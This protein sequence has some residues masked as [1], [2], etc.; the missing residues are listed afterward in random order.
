MLLLTVMISWGV[1]L[2]FAYLFVC[3]THFDYA[4][5]SVVD[6]LHCLNASMLDEAIAVSDVVTDALL[7]LFPLPLVNGSVIRST[8]IG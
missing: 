2:F 7:L 4:W 3:R 5:G 8:K 1:S 6:A